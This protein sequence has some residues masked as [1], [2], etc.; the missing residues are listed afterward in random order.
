MREHG[1]NR[2]TIKADVY[3]CLDPRTNSHTQ[4][5]ATR[6]ARI[7]ELDITPGG[8]TY[9]R[10]RVIS[11][12]RQAGLFW[13]VIS[14]PPPLCRKCTP[15]SLRFSPVIPPQNAARRF[16]SPTVAPSGR[17]RRD[18]EGRGKKTNAETKRVLPRKNVSIVNRTPPKERPSA[19]SNLPIYIP[20]SI[21]TI[22]TKKLL[23][24]QNT[25][26]REVCF[27]LSAYRARDGEFSPF[28]P[29]LL[30]SSLPT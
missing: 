14:S 24:R 28:F 27:G 16:L 22:P 9:V 8:A 1:E 10:P 25:R 30:R 20:I 19:L 18:V 4:T 12:V 21:P 2:R 11:S 5:K 26:L 29:S 17:E 13:L 15:V 6:V 3:A 23:R 7:G